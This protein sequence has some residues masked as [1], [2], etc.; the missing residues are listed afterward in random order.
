MECSDACKLWVGN[1]DIVHTA[2]NAILSHMG[3]WGVD[4]PKSEE[5]W[6]VHLADMIASQYY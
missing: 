5:D 4:R 3:R 1:G 6:I 2:G